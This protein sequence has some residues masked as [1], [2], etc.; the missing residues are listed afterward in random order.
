MKVLRHKIELLTGLLLQEMT[1]AGLHELRFTEEKPL[2]R[3]QDAELVSVGTTLALAPACGD[4]ELGR[5]G[6]VVCWCWGGTL[7]VCAGFGCTLVLSVRA[8]GDEPVW[9]STGEVCRDDG[10]VCTGCTSCYITLR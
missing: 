2:L 6:G 4:R 3:G 1:M 9:V 10:C 8:H 7:C 5:A